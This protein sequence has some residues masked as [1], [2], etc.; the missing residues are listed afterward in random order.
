M[1]GDR[2]LGLM[3]TVGLIIM[4][5]YSCETEKEFWAYIIGIGIAL[6]GFLVLLAVL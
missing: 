1:G 2:D 4:I 6:V 3:F 5:L